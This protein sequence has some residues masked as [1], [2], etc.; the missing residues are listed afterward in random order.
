M[1]E[2]RTP[3]PVGLSSKPARKQPAPG[4]AKKSQPGPIG[5]GAKKALPPSSPPGVN[6]G[7]QIVTFAQSKAGQR[8]GD[9]ECFALADQ[10]LKKAGAKSAADFG[11]ITDEADY[12]WGMQVSLNDVQ[13][14]DIV[15]FR[16]FEIARREDREDGSFVERTE[17]RPHHTAIVTSVDG[18]GLLT[19]MEQNSPKRSAV[20]RIQLG[21]KS[22]SFEHDKTTVTL[23]M[24]GTVWFFRP[25][26]K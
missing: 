10:A 12:K 5:V 25:Q 24:R 18:N 22:T 6:I 3:G 21:F 8:V 11:T 20:R 4:P 17:E 7:A 9:G 13:P 26:A 16:D 15:Q 2:P 1:A 14:G 19:V 23:T